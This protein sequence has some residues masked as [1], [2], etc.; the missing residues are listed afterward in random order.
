MIQMRGMRVTTGKLLNWDF[1]QDKTISGSVYSVLTRANFSS[2][3]L[4]EDFFF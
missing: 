4:S 2:Q 1:T 3:T